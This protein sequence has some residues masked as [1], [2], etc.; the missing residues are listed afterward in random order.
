MAAAGGRVGVIGCGNISRAYATKLAALPDL[1][2]VACADLDPSRARALADEFGV[3]QVLTPGELLAR[4]DVDVVLNLTVPGAHADVS[5]AALQAGKHCYS[6]KPLALDVAT[7]T[8]LVGRAR[9]AGLRL[10]CAPDTFL[11]AGL[12]ACRA[13]ID[14]GAIGTPLAANAFFQGSGPESWHP[15]PGMFYRRGA[16]PMFD[17]GPYYVTALVALLGPV[18]RVSGMARI[19]RARREITSQPLAGTWIDVEVPTHVAGVLEHESGPVAT[20]VTSFDVHASRYRFLEVYGSQG[21][22][23]VPDPNT[24]GGP[25]QLRRAGDADWADVPL[26]HAN[27]EQSRGLGLADMVRA[28][29]SGRPHRASGELALHVLEV[30]ERILAAAETGEHQTVASRVERPAPLAPG[31]E[32]DDTP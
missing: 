6:E 21:T 26:R 28:Q 19:S 20:L 8:R 17:M 5:E 22:L 16:G 13:L 32:D 23:A 11:G 12:Q 14:A 10:G 31:L 30:M 18:Q 7:G 9:D 29:R 3:P 2:L 4:S 15:D 27:A 24:F 1:D 25:V